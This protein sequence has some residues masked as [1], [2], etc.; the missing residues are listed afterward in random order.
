MRN[1]IFFNS[2][3]HRYRVQASVRRQKRLRF[4][5]SFAQSRELGSWSD[6]PPSLRL[7][8]Q[9][10]ERLRAET[11]PASEDGGGRVGWGAVRGAGVVSLGGRELFSVYRHEVC[12]ARP[13]GANAFGDLQ[14]VHHQPRNHDDVFVFLVSFFLFLRRRQFSHEHRRQFSGGFQKLF[15]PDRRTGLSLVPRCGFFRVAF[16]VAWSSE[17]WFHRS[18]RRN[19]TERILTRPTFYQR[20]FH[21]R[22]KLS[23][24]NAPNVCWVWSFSVLW[25]AFKLRR[26]ISHVQVNFC[27]CQTFGAAV[28]S[29]QGHEPFSCRWLVVVA[30][31]LLC[32]LKSLIFWNWTWSFQVAFVT[33]QN[34]WRWKPTNFIYFLL[35]VYNFFF[36]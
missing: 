9:L 31:E 19:S 12:V 5:E 24:Q 36:W 16:V 22:R 11:L 34:Y 6:L 26:R 2:R 33:D 35:K 28:V 23:A 15:C 20:V 29:Y 7:P 4:R 14:A 21:N 3:K 30:A 8:A 13:D 1:G 10:H 25:K 17:S 32:K 18:L 27:R